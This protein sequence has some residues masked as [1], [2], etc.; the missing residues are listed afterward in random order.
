MIDSERDKLLQRLDER[1]E[2]LDKR[3]G[4]VE[5][6][7]AELLRDLKYLKGAVDQIDN[8]LLHLRRRLGD[9]GLLSPER[10]D[11]DTE[12]MAAAAR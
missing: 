8:N 12:P 11:D 7:Q 10:A 6:G 2:R 3:L 9:D 4:N 5:A 1:T